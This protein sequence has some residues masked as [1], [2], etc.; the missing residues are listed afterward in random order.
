M[1]ADRY[2]STI[3]SSFCIFPETSRNE[4][5]SMTTICVITLK[6]F[7]GFCGCFFFLLMSLNGF[8][9]I[10]AES[11]QKPTIDICKIC[12]MT[13][14]SISC[15]KRFFVSVAL[16]FSSFIAIVAMVLKPTNKKPTTSSFAH[17]T[18][19]NKHLKQLKHA[20][21]QDLYRCLIYVV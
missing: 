16:V 19:Q 5:V 13:F 14:N 21:W 17:H 2:M 9:E 11:Q 12:S 20:P 4:C 7:S 15:V 3:C 18:T 10:A 1:L 8:G 6:G